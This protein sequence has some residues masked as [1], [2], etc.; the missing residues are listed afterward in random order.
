MAQAHNVP[1]LMYHHVAAQGGSL[2]VAADQFESQMRGLAQRGYR[3]LSASEFAD[4]LSG[5]AVPEKSVLITFDDGYLDNWV[6]AHPVLQ[7]YGMSAVLFTITGLIGD[8]A[9][10]PFQGQGIH[11]PDCPP[12]QEAKHLMFGNN[13]DAVMLRWAE[14]EAMRLAGTFEIHSHTHTHRRWDLECACAREK[15]DRLAHDLQMSRDAMRQRLGAT[16]AHLCWPQGY[17][18]HDYKRVAADQGFDYLYTTDA[19]GQNTATADPQHIYRFAVRNRPFAWLQQRLWLA[20][21]PQLGPLYN[22][23][24]ARSDARKQRRSA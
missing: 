23:W 5:A 17:F 24:K 21:H 16:T 14:I 13:P 10:R 19:R 12:H 8:G 3:S 6:Y 4:F 15:S 2:T 7:R 22:A 1:V 11:L 9:A 18:D 20:T